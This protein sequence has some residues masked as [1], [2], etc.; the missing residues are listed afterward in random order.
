[1][2]VDG[3]NGDGVAQAQV[4]KL[5]KIGV[6]HAGGVHLVH[7]QHDGL[8]AAQQHVGHFMVGGG[9]A[10]LNIRQKHDNGGV[11]NGDLGLVPHEFQNLVIRTGLDASGVDEGKLPAVPVGLPVN[12]VPGDARGILHDRKPLADQL[13]EQHG[14][15]HIGAAHDGNDGFHRLSHPFLI[16]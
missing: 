14:L 1:M 3:G 4:I 8:S 9:E 5:V 15:A 7:R 16:S 11:F 12:A 13:I 2:T 6:R 10:R